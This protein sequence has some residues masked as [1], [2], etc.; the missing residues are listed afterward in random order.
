MEIIKEIFSGKELTLTPFT[1]ESGIS[2][3]YC[4]LNKWSSKEKSVEIPLDIFKY[5][6]NNKILELDSGNFETGEEHFTYNRSHCKD[7]DMNTKMISDL[8]II[9]REIRLN[10]L[11]NS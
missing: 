3:G 8:K 11:T 9:R 10:K 4:T 7:L 2:S 5:L 6:V 1:T